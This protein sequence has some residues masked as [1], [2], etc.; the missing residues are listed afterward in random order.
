MLTGLS[1]IV[2]RANAGAWRLRK[3]C[4]SSIV[5]IES[6]LFRSA[7]SERNYKIAYLVAKILEK[8]LF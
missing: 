1:K 7:A 4:S 5:S 2:D 6:D 3:R 8:S